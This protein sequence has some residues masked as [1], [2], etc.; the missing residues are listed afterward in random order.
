MWRV[1]GGVWG[2]ACGVGV[3]SSVWGVACVECGVCM[4]WGG[5][6]DDVRIMMQGLVSYWE[7]EGGACSPLP[8][9]CL[10]KCHALI[11]R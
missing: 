5:G 1:A 9:T 7:S 6:I 10:L 4:L 11:I 8:I 3:G 2:V